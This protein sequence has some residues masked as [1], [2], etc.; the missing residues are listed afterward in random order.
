MALKNKVAKE[1]FARL[2]SQYDMDPDEAEVVANN[3]ADLIAASTPPKR[4]PAAK[5]KK[6]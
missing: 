4:K 1:E 5:K 3:H 2:R 6:K